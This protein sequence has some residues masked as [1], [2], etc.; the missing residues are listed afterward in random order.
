MGLQNRV[1]TLEKACEQK[2]DNP[3]IRSAFPSQ[4]A[5][6]QV[7]DSLLATFFDVIGK[8]FY[9]AE[10]DEVKSTVESLR[11]SGH[12]GIPLADLVTH[13]RSVHLRTQV[14]ELAGMAS[15]AVVH[16]QLIDPIT[17]PP[18]ELADHLYTIARYGLDSALQ[19][20]PLRAMKVAA[21]LSMYNIVVHATV[22]LTYA[23]AQSPRY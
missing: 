3:A 15:I 11:A 13:S 22:A 5:T 21:L 12:D 7:L 2:V 1:A 8:L 9:I 19:Y 4:D 14:S 6:L 20:D 16:A 17:S 10:K 18:I 23:G